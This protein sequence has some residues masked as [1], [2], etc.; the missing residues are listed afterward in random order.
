MRIQLVRT[1]QGGGE[2]CRAGHNEGKRDSHF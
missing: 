1:L 2:T